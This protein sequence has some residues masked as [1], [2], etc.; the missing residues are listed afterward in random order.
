MDEINQAAEP[1]ADLNRN[2]NGGNIVL[3]VIGSILWIS[4][5]NNIFIPEEE[6]ESRLLKQLPGQEI[7]LRWQGVEWREGLVIG[8]DLGY[9]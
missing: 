2:F 5:L 9:D 4:A 6:L 8:P 1:N 7:V 3:I